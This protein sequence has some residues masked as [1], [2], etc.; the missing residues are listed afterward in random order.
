ML[1]RNLL[2]DYDGLSYVIILYDQFLLNLQ[3]SSL[4]PTKI[5]LL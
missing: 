2:M 3:L 5:I 1:F 4:N